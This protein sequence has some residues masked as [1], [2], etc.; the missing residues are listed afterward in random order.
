MTDNTCDQT[1]DICCYNIADARFCCREC[2]KSVCKSC[3]NHTRT[4]WSRDSG[5][6][7]ELK[8]KNDK[9]F[10]FSLNTEVFLQEVKTIEDADYPIRCKYRCPY[11]R[12][13]ENYLNYEELTKDELLLFTKKDY[14][15]TQKLKINYQ[16]DLRTM[17]FMKLELDRLKLSNPVFDEDERIEELEKERDKARNDLIDLAKNFNYVM[18]I[19]INNNNIKQEKEQ[20]ILELKNIRNKNKEIETQFNNKLQTI[21]N[22]IGDKIPKKKA[23]ET[24]GKIKELINPPQRI[25]QQNWEVRID[26][27]PLL[28]MNR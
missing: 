28:P 12:C 19:L 2:K 17:L 16:K 7:G 27:S 15:H 20:A 10:C 11:C 21:N 18:D 8:A 26:L 22:I 5:E 3:Y 4:E 9:S 23:I 24:L 14:L 6:L 25:Y 13:D 1:C